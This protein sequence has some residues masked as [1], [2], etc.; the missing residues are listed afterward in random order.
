MKLDKVKRYLVLLMCFVAISTLNGQDTKMVNNTFKINPV[1]FLY[2]TL[3]VQYER[4]FTDRISAQLGASYSTKEVVIWEDLQAKLYGYSVTPEI[5]YYIPSRKILKNE[6]TAPVGFY[7]GVWATYQILNADLASLNNESRKTEI[8]KLESY[9]GGL[10]VGWQ[11]WLKI[12]KQPIIMLDLYTGIGYQN[13]NIQ[14]RIAE[15]GQF[16]FYKNKGLSPRLGLSLGY[17]F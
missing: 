2:S 10:M 13:S 4:V 6:T 9:A 8:L 7:T 15:K 11:A 16:L 3:D 17:S 14:G 5:R 12:K 1:G